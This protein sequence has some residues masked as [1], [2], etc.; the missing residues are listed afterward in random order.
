MLRNWK[1]ITL[2]SSDIRLINILTPQEIEFLEGEDPQ[3]MNIYLYP[4][5]RSVPSKQPLDPKLNINL[6]AMV[7]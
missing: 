7:Q 2:G 4:T 6:S 5:V 3:G 1:D